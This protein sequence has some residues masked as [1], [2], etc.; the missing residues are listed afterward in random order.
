MNR[1]DTDDS[2][3]NYSTNSATLTFSA[4]ARVPKGGS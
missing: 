3:I 1:R 2:S 4:I